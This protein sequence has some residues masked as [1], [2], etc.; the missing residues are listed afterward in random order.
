[1]KNRKTHISNINELCATKV[2]EY[3]SGKN[4]SAQTYQ[5]QIRCLHADHSKEVIQQLVE[6]AEKVILEIGN[7]SNTDLYSFHAKDV[8]TISHLREVLNDVETRFK[9]PLARRSTN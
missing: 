6:S 8:A 4:I 1:M 7:L 3:K 9:Q 5:R 2:F